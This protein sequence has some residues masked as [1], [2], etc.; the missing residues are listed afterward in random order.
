MTPEQWQ[1]AETA[2]NVAARNS[3]IHDLAVAAGWV[4]LAVTLYLVAV[5]AVDSVRSR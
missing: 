4:A 3:I 1:H 5:I 2:A